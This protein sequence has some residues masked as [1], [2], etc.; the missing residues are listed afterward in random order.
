VFHQSAG[1]ARIY[2]KGTEKMAKVCALLRRY[3]GNINR[4]CENGTL[5]V[6]LLKFNVV[7]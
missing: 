1:V 7:G 4:P 2:T 6:R 3:R 5:L